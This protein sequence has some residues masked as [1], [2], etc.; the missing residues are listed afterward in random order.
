LAL[1]VLRL[2][3]AKEGLFWYNGAMNYMPFAFLNMVNLCILL[4]VFYSN[5]NRRRIVLSIVSTV[6]SFLISGGNHVTAFANILF[7]LVAAIYLFT[8]K[9]FFAIGP[10]LSAVIGFIIVYIAPGTALRQKFLKQQTVVDT[11]VATLKWLRGL[12]GDWI[13]FSWLICMLAVTPIAIEIAM[14]NKDKFSKRFPLIHILIAGAVICG[15]LCVPYLPMGYFGEIR[16][17]N[18]IYV[19]FIFLSIYIYVLLWGYIV[20]KDYINIKALPGSKYVPWMRAAFVSVCVFAM[21]FFQD[22]GVNSNSWKAMK[23]LR[24]GT[25]QAYCREMDAR[26]E[27]YKDD[28]LEEVVVKPLENFPEL[29]FMYDLGAYPESWPNTSIGSYYGKEIYVELEEDREE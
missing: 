22:G 3:S 6:L 16:I 21:F 7:L 15:M 5:S 19:T 2:P 13:S 4:D 29:L 11:I 12:I 1:I 24:I 26:I 27:K 10:F 8:K 14:K 9:R 18:V 25:P 20:A 23:E 28:S 17:T